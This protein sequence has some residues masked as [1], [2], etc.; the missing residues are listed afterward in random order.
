V[1]DKDLIEI[2]Y[3]NW[4]GERRMRKVRPIRLWYGN[5][6]WHP[7]NQWLMTAYDPVSGEER[8]F[9]MVGLPGWKDFSFDERPVKEGTV[10]P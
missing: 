1:S 9:A 10:A 3:T 8:D 7:S 2:D 6:E 5:T 4:R